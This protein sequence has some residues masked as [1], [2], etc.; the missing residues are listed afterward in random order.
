MSGEDPFAEYEE[1]KSP[2]RESRNIHNLLEEK[3]NE[4]QI[5]LCRYLT[6][7][8][9]AEMKNKVINECTN[10]FN[11]DSD[12]A[13]II[14]MY[15]KWNTLK[16]KDDWFSKEKD[17]RE[18]CGIPSEKSRKDMNTKCHFCFRTINQGEDLFLNCKHAFCPNCLVEQL[19]EILNKGNSCL[20]ANCPYPRCN[21]RIKASSFKKYLSESDYEKYE[22]FIIDNFIDNSKEIKR[23]PNRN[24]SAI[25]ERIYP[26][27][28]EITCKECGYIFCFD[29]NYDAHFPISC[30]AKKSL[31]EYT[32]NIPYETWEIINMNNNEIFDGEMAKA[33]ILEKYIFNYAKYFNHTHPKIN[34]YKLNC[35]FTKFS[36]GFYNIKGVSIQE[37]DF[38]Y[39]ALKILINSHKILANSYAI[40]CPYIENSKEAAFFEFSRKELELHTEL[41]QKMLEIDTSQ[42]LEPYVSIEQFFAYKLEVNTKSV[43]VKNY[44]LNL[45]KELLLAIPKTNS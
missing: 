19:K 42:F 1:I 31:E 40:C 41:L 6:K 12:E 17:I 5:D 30:E 26:S 35:N 2:Q 20:E 9:I 18:S 45:C 11:I 21:N 24:C 10:L 4:I 23:C 13:L 39:T 33:S 43:L 34:A 38:L 14:L 15:Y 36:S 37:C 7:K 16:L 22:E 29:C 32:K 3:K 28:S 8:Q 27:I 44:S 25:M